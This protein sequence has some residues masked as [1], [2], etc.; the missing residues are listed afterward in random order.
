MCVLIIIVADQFPQLSVISSLSLMNILPI[1]HQKFHLIFTTVA[2]LPAHD[3][4]LS[5]EEINK[6]ILTNLSV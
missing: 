5:I 2:N 3:S 4:L 1:L 6:Y